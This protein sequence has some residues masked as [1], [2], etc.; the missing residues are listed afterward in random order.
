MTNAAKPLPF[1]THDSIYHAF[2][3]G[4]KFVVARDD[5]TSAAVTRI[6]L[7]AGRG[8]RVE[9]VN[10]SVYGM[11]RPDGSNPSA[12]DVRLAIAHPI[13][14][15][16]PKPYEPALRPTSFDLSSFGKGKLF[17]NPKTGE[18]VCGFLVTGDGTVEVE[19]DNG[20]IS[21]NYRADGT[22][23]HTASRDLVPQPEKPKTQTMRLEVAMFDGRVEH[24]FA[25]AATFVPKR[26]V[27]RIIGVGRVIVYTHEFEVPA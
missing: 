16:A 20:R 26:E 15:P 21:K 6:S 19:F 9:T 5:Q 1:T 2:R 18:V 8:V 23:R 7:V 22:H 10:G 14:A 4:T 12:R 27:G 24:R 11:F 3:A 25:P 13:P 17:H